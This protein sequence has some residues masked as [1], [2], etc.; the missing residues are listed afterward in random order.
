MRPMIETAKEKTRESIKKMRVQNETSLWKQPSKT[1]NNGDEESMIISI[2]QPQKLV[3][4]KESIPTAPDLVFSRRCSSARGNAL[5]DWSFKPIFQASIHRTRI[6][7]S[8]T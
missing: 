7:K 2:V 6:I 3:I 5:N 1:G 8:S 4:H